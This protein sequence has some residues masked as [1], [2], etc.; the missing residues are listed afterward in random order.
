MATVVVRDFRPEDVDDLYEV[1]L[2]TGN[3]GEDASGLVSSPRLLGDVYVGPYLQQAPD[4][5][6]VADDGERAS[7]YALGVLDTEQFEQSLDLTWWPTVQA[8]YQSTKADKTFDEELLA[9][10]RNPDLTRHPA[11]PGYPSHL[12]IDLM[13]HLRG[14][15]VGTQMLGVLF[16]R[17]RRSGS[18]GVHLGVDAANVG[19][20]R[21]YRHLGFVELHRTA[22]ELFMGLS[23]P[24]QSA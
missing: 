5:A 17:L 23:W 11:L 14:R 18:P 1:C 21:F 6:L 22:D 15:G 9:L 13:S 10:I 2:L 4:L 20:Q 19:A 7:G 12:H 16:E 24:S 8:R 3:A